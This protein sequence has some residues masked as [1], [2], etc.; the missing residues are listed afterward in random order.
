MDEKEMRKF[1]WTELFIVTS[2]CFFAFCG[3]LKMLGGFQTG[4]FLK[5]GSISL[6]LGLISWAG[7][8]ISHHGSKKSENYSS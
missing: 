7:K 8:S 6:V 1:S 2:C 3:I 5:V 4:F